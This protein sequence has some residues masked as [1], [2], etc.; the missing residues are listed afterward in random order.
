LAVTKF[1]RVLSAE[2]T[3]VFGQLTRGS[4]SALIRDHFAR[5]FAEHSAG[6]RRASILSLAIT[7]ELMLDSVHAAMLWEEGE[8]PAQAAQVWA[9][10]NSITSRVKSLYADRLGGSWR[11]DAD[12][13]VRHWREQV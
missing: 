8:S 13:P 11:L 1:S 9:K 10:A 12:N 3:N 4:I 2:G 7:C 5:S 6:D